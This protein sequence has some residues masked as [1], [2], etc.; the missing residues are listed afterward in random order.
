MDER[1]LREWIA[2]VKAARLSRR[3][4]TRMLAGLG[5][6]APMAAQLLAAAGVPRRAA[7]RRSPR[8]RRPGAAAAGELKTL[9]WQAASS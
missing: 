9:W 7:P 6:T 4:F 1:E 3:R 5:L 2:R 8:S